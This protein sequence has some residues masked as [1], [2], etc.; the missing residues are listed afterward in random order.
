MNGRLVTTL[1][2]LAVALLVAAALLTLLSLTGYGLLAL[3]LGL[4]VFGLAELLGRRP[5]GP[6]P[7]PLA[8]EHADRLRL[9]R[10][11]HGQVAAVREL[12]HARPELS[13]ADAAR[14]VREL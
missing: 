6:P 10:D 2:L 9:V 13:L 3:G 14:L 7:G 5:S 4:G 1:R 8:S 12:R 11:E